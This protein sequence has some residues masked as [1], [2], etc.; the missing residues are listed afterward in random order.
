[1][2]KPR[3]VVRVANVIA[4][5]SLS[6][7]ELQVIEALRQLGGQA[8]NV[9][10]AETLSVSDETIRR[11]IKS[12]SKLGIVERNH[13]MVR[14]L[15]AQH[16]IGFFQRLGEFTEEKMQVAKAVASLV[17]DGATL[18]LDV[19][20]TTAF[21]A[22][23]LR[24]RRDLTVVTNSMNVAHKLLA[25]NGNRVFLLGGEMRKDEMGTFGFV[26]EAQVR[27]YTYDIAILSPDALDPKFGFLY[28]SPG[29]AELASVV[30]DRTSRTMIAMVHQKFDTSGPHQGFEP[31]AVD[32]LITDALP[33]KKLAAKLEGWQIKTL[34][35]A[36]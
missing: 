18:F 32:Q 13:G 9:E 12:L 24:D 4:R 6:P 15:D 31:Q 22:E 19:G 3:K 30:V 34:L 14:L 1:M 27:R 2:R 16:E 20:S 28:Q 25:H 29:E 7:R 23:T 11:T 10:L 36:E 8:R 33:G 5:N 26:A 17:P 21:V 35:A